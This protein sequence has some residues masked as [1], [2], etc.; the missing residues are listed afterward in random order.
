MSLTLRRSLGLLAATA[1]LVSACGASTTPSPSPTE[2]PATPP[3]AESPSAEPSM[4]AEGP[5]L[6]DT[7]YAT[8]RVDGVRGG[9]L[10]IGDWQEANLWNPFYQGQ[11]I[12]ATV[13]AALWRG[14]ATTTYDFKYAGDLA[15][16][17]LPTIQNGGV[18]VEGD[19]MKVTFKLRDGLKWSDGTALTCA[20]VEATWK[21]VMDPANTG[22]YGGTTGWEVITAVDCSTEGSV[23]INFKEQYF[24]YLVLYSTQ[25]PVL[26]KAY[27]ESI[28]IADQVNGK[29]WAATD[30]PNVPVSGPFK[31]E[32]VTPGQELRLVRNDSYVNPINGETALL[33]SV[34]W[35][36]YGDADAMIAGYRAGETDYISDLADADLPKVLDLGDQVQALP[37]LQYEFFRPQWGTKVDGTVSPMSDLAMRRGPPVRRRQGR[38]QRPP[39]GRPGHDRLHEHLAERLVLRPATSS[40]GSSTSTRRRRSS[41]PAAGPSG[42]TG[43]ARRTAMKAEILLCTTTRQLRQDTLA[44]VA[45]D[46]AKIGIKATVQA[47]SRGG[48]LRHVQ[49]GHRRDAVQPVAA[50]RLGRRAPHLLGAAQPELQL[51]HLPLVAARAERPERRPGQRPGHRQDPHRAQDHGRLREGPGAHEGV[52][53]GLRGAGRG[54][55]ALLPQG[56]QRRPA[57]RQEL[58]RQP[59]LRRAHLELRRLVHPEVASALRSAHP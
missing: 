4:P 29:G 9:T 40:S 55:P 59:D 32:S 19:G 48:H 43:S 24:D 39:H 45:A 10:I 26:P 8:Q 56:R 25:T 1:V 2:A 20:D 6:F 41:T 42:P 58:V 53:E 21:W 11:V 36:W 50:R 7:D 51:P 33:D 44:L 23:V 27:I 5:A 16:D 14:L 46:L 3:P 31:V 57:V 15:Q 35:K 13:S 30:M 54:D 49:R 38:H 18:V 17:P 28:P 34:V 22:L 52:P 12:E 37:A 47:V